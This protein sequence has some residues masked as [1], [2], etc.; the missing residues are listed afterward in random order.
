[1][2]S[3]TTLGKRPMKRARSD[4]DTS[5]TGPP[6]KRQRLQSP[7]SEGEKRDLLSDSEGLAKNKS[8]AIVS[9]E[10]NNWETYLSQDASE[11][12]VVTFIDP[13]LTEPVATESDY[14]DENVAPPYI[15]TKPVTVIA[16]FSE[17]IDPAEIQARE[18]SWARCHQLTFLLA[19]EVD[20]APAAP[21][22]TITNQRLASP[23]QLN[24][25]YQ[26]IGAYLDDE[27][28]SKENDEESK[29]DASDIGILQPLESEDKIANGCDSVVDFQIYIDA[30]AKSNISD[31]NAS[32]NVSGDDKV[33]LLETN[34]DVA[35]D[36]GGGDDKEPSS[37]VMIRPE[38]RSPSPGSEDD[39]WMH[40][41]ILSPIP[42]SLL[43]KVS[44][45]ASG[46]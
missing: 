26:S 17:P 6:T 2:V 16:P 3:I 29:S 9:F 40:R 30:D 31:S 5:G 18:E 8:D 32:D 22:A 39:P 46:A 45:D 34:Q 36:L 14:G 12:D 4:S 10:P 1:M 27:A 25:Q 7:D 19:R 42:V 24:D 41:H 35:E 21:D 37:Y 15:L 33:K 38:P 44:D 43:H 20:I 28:E 11:S 23:F 13:G